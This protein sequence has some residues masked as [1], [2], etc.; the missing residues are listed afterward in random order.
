M[1][2]EGTPGLSLPI[3]YRCQQVL[4]ELQAGV[5][6]GELVE[7][8]GDTY[9]WLLL[10]DPLSHLLFTQ[11][12]AWIAWAT[13]QEAALVAGR[14]GE[15]LLVLTDLEVLPDAGKKRAFEFPFF[16]QPSYLFFV[17]REELF[18]VFI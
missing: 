6:E 3:W 10:G 15:F 8:G 5:S 16:L 12:S 18:R 4:L 1:H 9:S 17:D 7:V 2:E 13:T 14:R 11:Q